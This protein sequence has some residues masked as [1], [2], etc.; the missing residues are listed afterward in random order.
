MPLR[1]RVPWLRRVDSRILLVFLVLV[2][3]LL[4]FGKIASEMIEGDTLAFDRWLLVQLRTAADPG[5]PV[6][7]R[8]LHR[9]MVDITA[10]GGGAVLTLITLL[11]AGYLLVRR[12]TALAVYLG[13]AIGAGGLLN[14]LLK[15]GFVRDRPD[16]VPHLVE[17]SS[18]SFPSGHAMNSATVYLTLA[19]LLAGAERNW[20][21]RIFLLSAA[22][23]VTI[24]VGFSRAYLGVHWP[25]D[26]MAGWSVGAAWAALCS[27]V[28][29][30]LQRTRVVEG[31][32]TTEEPADEAA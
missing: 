13:L 32:E 1:D 18:A 11:A 23:L 29:L 14:S 17:V 3:S 24:L 25:T 27:L 30:R 5:L 26:V 2:P 9:A 6:G 10:L 28:A 4:L 8:W 12:K 31:S 21:V 20:R 22:V 19:A 16:I 7:P 15:Y